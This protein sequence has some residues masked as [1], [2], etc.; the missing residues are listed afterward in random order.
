MGATKNAG[1]RILTDI[2]GSKQDQL[3]HFGLADADDAEDFTAKLSSL[4]EVWELLL[5]GFHAWFEK[6]RKEMFKK[7][8]VEA[9]KCCMGLVGNFSTT[10]LGSCTNCKRGVLSG[11]GSSQEVTE[12]GQYYSFTTI[13][14]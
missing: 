4:K 14:E 9:A 6:R 13:T 5:P 8:I 11:G 1:K 10:D 7:T 12:S 2:Y 3:Q